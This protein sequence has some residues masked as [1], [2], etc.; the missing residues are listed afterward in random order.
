MEKQILGEIDGDITNR[1][2]ESYDS[3]VTFILLPVC[4]GLVSGSRRW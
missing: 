4:H 2:S 1:H 3:Q